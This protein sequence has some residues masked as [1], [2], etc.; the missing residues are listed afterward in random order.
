[1]SYLQCKSSQKIVGVLFSQTLNPQRV[2]APLYETTY[3]LGLKL[4][5]K[6]RTMISKCL[7]QA[8]LHFA[9]PC[10]GPPHTVRTGRMFEYLN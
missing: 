3:S 10:D 2:K 6:Y 8:E 5:E 4:D 1:M 7:I 9:H